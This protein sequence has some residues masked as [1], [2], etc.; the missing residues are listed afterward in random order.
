M[1]MESQA[2]SSLPFKMKF[3]KGKTARKYTFWK[4]AEKPQNHLSRVW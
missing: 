1:Q 3:K 4:K 2:G